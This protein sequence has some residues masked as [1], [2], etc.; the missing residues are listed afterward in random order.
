LARALDGLALAYHD[1]AGVAQ[2][3]SDTPDPPPQDY[4][5]LRDMA[6]LRFP[7]LGFY[8]SPLSVPLSSTLAVQAAWQSA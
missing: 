7:E 8:H 2:G 1:T 4:R 3:D 5:Q 6:A